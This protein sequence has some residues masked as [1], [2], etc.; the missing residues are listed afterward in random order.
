MLNASL[1]IDGSNGTAQGGRVFQRVGPTSAGAAS[2]AP[3]GTAT[4]AKLA[5]DAAARAFSTWRESGPGERRRL[6]TE[7]ARRL[8]LSAPALTEAMTAELGA[9]ELWAKTNLH[10]GAEMLVEAAALTTQIS[11]QIIPSDVQGSLALAVRQPA[12]VC[13]GIAPWN[14]PVILAVRAVATAL[15]CGNTVILKGSELCPMTHFLVAKCFVDAGFPPGVVNYVVNAPADAPAVVEALIAHPATRRVNFTGSTKVG[16]I[17][18]SLA[19][20]SMK[21]ALLELGGKAPLL[22]LEDADLDEAARA[23]AFG[24][25][26]N[27]GQICMST[28]RVIVADAIAEAFA[29]KLVAHVSSF[30][31]PQAQQGPLGSVVG[32]NA[33]SHC[34]ALLD[35]AIGKGARLL[36]GG[37]A[38]GT[39]MD[40]TIVD[41]VTPQMRLFHEESFGPMVGLIRFGDEAEALSLAN[42]SEYGLSSAIFSRDISKAMALARRID[43]G[44]C[45]INGPTVHDEPQMP[46]GGTKQSG[47]GRFGGEAGIAEFTELRWI[48]IQTTSRKYPF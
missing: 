7:A 18:G 3:A 48:T 10:L 14:A 34:K 15:A 47:L 26:A 25:F 20:A 11:G 9:T 23:V 43:S 42:A 17:I 2:E 28:E 37:T 33:V 38:G 32:T 35:D 24:A 5:V 21:P 4:D 1:I 8:E 19:A 27:C 6:L 30:A 44:I 39:F 12:G 16:R 13:L 36:H 29:R 40:A 31:L 22:V 45:H 46:F 41:S